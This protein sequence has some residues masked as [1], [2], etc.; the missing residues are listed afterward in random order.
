MKAELARQENGDHAGS[1]G[2]ADLAANERSQTG[3]ENI[4]ILRDVKYYQMLYELLAKQYEI[5]R[6]DESKDSSIVQV[7]DRADEPKRKY[8]PRRS[9]IVISFF[10]LGL[11]MAIFIVLILEGV[12]GAEQDGL[13]SKLLTLRKTLFSFK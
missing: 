2:G 4:K 7:L 10:L 11:F 9:I 3:L 6:L 12:R 8:K 1:A 13:R 5:A